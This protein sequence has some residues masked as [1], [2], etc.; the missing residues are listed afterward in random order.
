[1]CIMFTSKQINIMADR[2]IASKQN[3]DNKKWV[4][5]IS[6]VVRD[7]RNA[8]ISKIEIFIIGSRI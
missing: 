2:S 1:M 7:N 3:K 5:W 6:K 4:V 8:A